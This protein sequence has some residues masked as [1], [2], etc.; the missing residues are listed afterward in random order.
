VSV[1][2]PEFRVEIETIAPAADGVVALTLRRT[3]GSPLPGW[4]PGAHID[5]LLPSGMVRQ[6]S[7]CGDP[8]DLRCWRI[9]VLREQAGRGG[10]AEVHDR[11]RA[12][13][14]L[15][16]RGPRNAFILHPGHRYLFVAGGIG[17]TP[18]LPMVREAHRLGADWRLLY[19]GRSRA[20]M[21]F[22]EELQAI[23]ESRVEIWPQDKV[24]LLDLARIQ[25]TA[26]EGAEIYCCGPAGLLNVLEERFGAAGLGDALHIERFTPAAVDGTALRVILARSGREVTVGSHCS[27]LEALRAAGCD[28]PS[29]CE[30][31]L[32]G[33]CETKV[34]AGTPDHRDQLLTDDER[35]RG[36]VMMVCVSRALTSTLTLDL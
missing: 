1:E 11:L 21:A 35:E 18:I 23:D 16:V 32:C 27:I 15:T 28:V 2:A 17:I 30:Q 5:L 26:S 9:A 6:Y 14:P 20:S 29:S 24:G 33:T 36:D 19:G 25:A 4:Q 3:D 12:G 31:G 8:S 7:L 34:L 13:Q 22:V 10:S